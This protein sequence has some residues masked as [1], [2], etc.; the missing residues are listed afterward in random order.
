[1]AAARAHTR[2]QMPGDW[3]ATGWRS[4]AGASAG[5][6]QS[7]R[8]PSVHLPGSCGLSYFQTMRRPTRTVPA[9]L[10]GP[11][12][13]VLT[14]LAVLGASAV[15]LG[16]P[17]SPP[18]APQAPAPTP[19]S[20]NPAPTPA[21]SPAPQAPQ[22]PAPPAADRHVSMESST[23]RL[24]STPEV[25]DAMRAR[26]NQ[27]LELRAASFADLNSKGSRVLVSTRF[28]STSQVHLVKNPLGARSQ[29]TFA[30]EPA[31]FASFDP[32]DDNAILY[33]ADIGGNENFQIFRQDL[34]SGRTVRLTDE[35]GRNGAALWSKDGTQIAYESTARNQRDYDIWIADGRD[36]KSARRIVDGKGAWYPLDWSHD[37]K[38]LLVGEYISIN[39]SRIYLVDIASKQVSPLSPADAPASY[40][41]AL[42][43]RNDKTIYVI[44]D[45]G[46][47]FLDLYETDAKGQKWRSLTGAINWDI[48]SMSLSSDGRTLA[49]SINK[50]GYFSLSLVDTRSRKITPVKNLPDGLVSNIKFAK[51]ANVLG[52][53]LSS[54]TSPG[55]AY[56]YDI[57]RR[58]LTRWT[59]SEMGGL[60]SDNLSAPTLIEFPT[61]DGRKIPAFYYKPKGQG[62]FPVAVNI[63]G[64]PESQARARFSSLTQYLLAESGIA[65]IY[66]NVRGSSGYGKS[67]L[68][69]DNGFK[70]E[71]SVKD[72]G[73][74]LDWIGKQPELDA[75]RV[76]VMGGS[77]GGYM[78]LAS[79]IHFG[80]RLVAG[81]DNVGISNFVTFLENTADYRRDLRRAEYGDER[82]PEMRAYQQ[83]ISPTNNVGK[84]KSALFV[85][86]G[87][88]DPRV[89]ASEGRQIV[90][91]V[92]SAGHDVWYML[93]KNEGHGFRKK[94]N[95]DLY[96]LYIVMFLEKH[97]GVAKN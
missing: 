58:K 43:A 62:P 70:R 46:G 87:A 32:R 71:D 14:V 93:A 68:L 81:I 9:P 7:E 1:M 41:G 85:A 40:S 35:K 75:K 25:A 54:A 51:K 18:L 3:L 95:R 5:C 47:E 30:R 60:Q 15:M 36:P 64:G 13:P 50:G 67:Y 76:A 63:H 44:S 21:P 39:E 29:L 31:R 53:T 89:P 6:Q 86:Q 88:N 42:F 72:I 80:D 61:F 94:A 69:L 79:L 33:V 91:A 96:Y 83:K 49:V 92:R 37:G 17:S 65:V 38:K 78:V 48:R 84:I 8:E 52:F 2:P 27:Y 73:A 12:L 4:N 20:A 82:N 19:V 56:T 10:A 55:D 97:L 24:E 74:L 34:T 59:E 66:P 26:M 45:R 77:Y 57:R 16:C 28:G 90:D 11:P 22:Q 23:L